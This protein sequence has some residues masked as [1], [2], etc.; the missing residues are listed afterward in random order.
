MFLGVFEDDG[1]GKLYPL[2]F[3]R[4]TFEIRLGYT[5]LGE[6]IARAFPDL[7]VVYFARPTLAPVL[8][9]RLGR[10]VNDGAAV[11][12]AP[13]LLV[14][15]SVVFHDLE[16]DAE[17]PEEI[18][19]CGDRLV[20]VRLERAPDFMARPMVEIVRQLRDRVPV[21]QKQVYMITYPWDILPRTGRCIEADFQAMGSVLEGHVSGDASI[22]GDD[23]LIHM[24]ASVAIQPQVVLDTGGGPIIFG[25]NAVVH[26]HT[27]I[28][29][30][31]SIGR[32]SMI[33]GGK[34][35]EDTAVGPMC[36]VG[37]EVE[38]SIFQGYSNKYHD[39][40]I[41]HAWVG[42]WVNLGALTTNSDLKNDY[43]NVQV[44]IE[45]ETVDTCSSKVGCF[46]GDHTKTGIGTLIN[47]GSVIGVMCNILGGDATMPKYIP[48]FCWYYN[49]MIAKGLGLRAGMETARVAMARRDVRLEEDDVALLQHTYEIT[50]EEREALI[51]RDRKKLRV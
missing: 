21:V 13:I 5:T 25:E 18:C 51:K 50:K 47:T 44:R 3:L 11:E 15:G 14:N 6:K 37:G 33:V 7:S 43:S 27:R 46:I 36:R 8:R 2:T 39:G 19:M 26:P 20:Y 16:I 32:D 24:P 45:G 48:S 9:R 34:I 42:E 12:G 49:G 38:A 22:Y 1:Y 29:G 17:G 41:G 4:A 35:R 10:P 23:K 31:A 30:P 28:E 40:F